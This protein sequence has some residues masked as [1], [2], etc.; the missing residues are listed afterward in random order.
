VFLRI[1]SYNP[2]EIFNYRTGWS[3][4]FLLAIITAIA[5]GTLVPAFQAYITP[6]LEYKTEAQKAKYN[7]HF[8]TKINHTQ[9]SLSAAAAH[10]MQY[11]Q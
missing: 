2:C 11:P 7:V 5:N 10:K 3:R 9:I 6:S 1:L 4:V 8:I